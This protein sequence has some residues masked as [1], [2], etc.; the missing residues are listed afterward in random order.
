[1]VC[2]IRPGHTY[3]E[4][5][6]NTLKYADRAKKIKNKPTINEDPQAAFIRALQEENAKLKAQ[7][8]AGGGGGGG[9]A[10]GFDPEAARKLAEAE[11]Q[12]RQNQLAMEEMEKSWEQKLEEQKHREDE[13]K[14]K[15]RE[16]EEAKLSGNP[17]ILNLNEDGMLDRKIFV[18]LSKHVGAKVGRKKPDGQDQ[19]EICLGGIGI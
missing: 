1:M 2:A 6:L 4:E 11:E 15:E 3:Y 9:G 13:E 10:G 5:T 18:D 14:Q 7:L 12:M 8:E 17:Q 16:I 19:P